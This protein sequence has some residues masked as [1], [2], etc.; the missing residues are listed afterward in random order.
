M[1]MRE[2][3]AVA[4]GLGI[5]IQAHGS[6][7]VLKQSPE[8]SKPLTLSRIVHLYFGPASAAQTDSDHAPG[9]RGG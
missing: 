3:L 5:K 6:G 1:T 2:A 9:A 7:V 4:S 8:A